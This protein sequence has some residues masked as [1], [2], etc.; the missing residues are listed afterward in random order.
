MAF[1]KTTH[2]TSFIVL[3]PGAVYALRQL[4]LGECQKYTFK[5]ETFPSSV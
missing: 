5:N 2:L 1:V 3:K 4:V